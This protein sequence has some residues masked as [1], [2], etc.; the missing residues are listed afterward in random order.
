LFSALIIPASP[1]NTQR[2]S[3][4]PRRSRLDLPD[5]GD[6]HGVAREDPAAHGEALAGHRQADDHLGQIAALVL[7]FPTFALSGEGL[8]TGGV[9][10]GL[11]VV[12]GVIDLEVYV[13]RIS[14]TTH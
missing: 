5:R 13:R 2:P 12:V 6:I 3:R 11:L 7:G 14:G 8:S 1:T 9:W 4:Q 10:S